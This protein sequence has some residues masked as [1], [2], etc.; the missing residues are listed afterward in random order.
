MDQEKLRKR[1]K[2]IKALQNISYKEISEYL[3]IE[4]NSLYNYLRGQYDLS[5]EKA[6]LLD[7]I[8]TTLW[9]GE[10]K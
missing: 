9:E 1:I 10:N 8:L 2:M 6:R 7:D 4:P 5:Y 3:D